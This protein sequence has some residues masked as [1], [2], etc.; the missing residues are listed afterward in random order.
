MT[1]ETKCVDNYNRELLCVCNDLL[2]SIL[3]SSAFSNVSQVFMTVSSSVIRL[4]FSSTF[5]SS[6]LT[7]E[8]SS[9]IFSASISSDRSIAVLWYSL[10]LMWVDCLVALEPLLNILSPVGSRYR[11]TICQTIIYIGKSKIII[12]HLEA[13][14]ILVVA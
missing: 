7:R 3:F 4:F 14:L 10:D 8:L 2:S 5:V 12:Y 1:G 13:H 9:L 11:Y 6:A